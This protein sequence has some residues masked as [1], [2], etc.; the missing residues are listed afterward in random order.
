MLGSLKIKI[1]VTVPLSKAL[2]SHETIVCDQI[3]DVF[4]LQQQKEMAKSMYLFLLFSVM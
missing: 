1:K 3:V 4:L 2:I